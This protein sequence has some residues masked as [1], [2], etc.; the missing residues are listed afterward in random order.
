M[1]NTLYRAHYCGVCVCT[2][3]FI[4]N[5][6]HVLSCMAISLLQDQP[7]VCSC[8]GMM[9]FLQR[10]SQKKKMDNPTIQQTFIYKC[11]LLNSTINQEK[12]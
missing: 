5:A 7:L 8:S 10:C 6:S 2:G 12:L 11:D 9:Q 3:S 1:D 4:K